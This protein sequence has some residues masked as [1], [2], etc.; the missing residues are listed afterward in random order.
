MNV[1]TGRGYKPLVDVS[2]ELRGLLRDMDKYAQWG[3]GDGQE[4]G[5]VGRASF[6]GGLNRDISTGI[7]KNGKRPSLCLPHTLP[8]TT[9]TPLLALRSADNKVHP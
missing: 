6:G 5:M 1:G 4:V 2:R 3:D 9:R 8:P 7:E